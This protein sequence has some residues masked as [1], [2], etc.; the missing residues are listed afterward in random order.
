MGNPE[1]YKTEQPQVS[2]ETREGRNLPTTLAQRWVMVI[3]SSL[4]L[5]ADYNLR[6]FVVE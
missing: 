1:N 4:R 3:G 6:L 5:L 2:T